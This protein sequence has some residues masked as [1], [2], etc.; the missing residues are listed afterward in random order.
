MLILK[1]TQQCYYNNGLSLVHN[2]QGLNQHLM[3]YREV[4][5]IV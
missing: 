4:L 2:V 1:A 5:N 3:S